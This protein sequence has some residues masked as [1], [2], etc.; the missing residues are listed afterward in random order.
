MQRTR[1]KGRER[2]RSPSGRG[3]TDQKAIVKFFVPALILLGLLCG[4]C[5]HEAPGKSPT[6]QPLASPQDLPGLPNFGRVSDVLYRGAQPS[7][8]G[9]QRLKQMGVKTV[10]DLRGESH[11]DELE[12]LGLKYVHIPTTVFQ[13]EDA[14]VVDFLRVVRDPANQPVFVHCERGA[15]RTGCYIAEYR[16]VEQG[17][18][19]PDAQLELYN[20][21]Y[22]PFFGGIITYL[23]R[24]DPEHVRRQLDTA[25][26]VGQ[27]AHHGDT[28][29]TEKRNVN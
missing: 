6:T 26:A 5:A 14:K 2:N 4:S 22:N 7:P 17:W 18:S 16:M 29:D 13:I 21:R 10:V 23:R 9:F 1:D 8:E 20:F 27:K 28:E 25:A 11:R 3:E 24:L 12:D 15:D 19:E